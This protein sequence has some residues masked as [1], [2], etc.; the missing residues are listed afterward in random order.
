MSRHML[1][2]LKHPN[3]DRV[4][5]QEGSSS[6]EA[7]NST[8]T[9]Q[10]LPHGSATSLCSFLRLPTPI[11]D[12]AVSERGHELGDFHN[13]KG[14][15]LEE[16][17]FKRRRGLHD[18]GLEGQEGGNKSEP[19]GLKSEAVQISD[20]E[21][22]AGGEIFPVDTPSPRLFEQ[23]AAE[24]PKGPMTNSPW[25]KGFLSSPLKTFGSIKA[26]GTNTAPPTMSF[27]LPSPAM[28]L[29]KDKDKT[30]VTKGSKKE[31]ARRKDLP[32]SSSVNARGKPS[33]WRAVELAKTK[34]HVESAVKAIEKDYY[35]NSSR[36][37]IESRRN[38]INN[39]FEQLAWA[40]HL[41]PI[42]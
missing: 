22:T 9:N 12:V 7:N 32:V 38:T 36:N 14:E 23:E 20:E 29:G 41:T 33:I 34:A 21:H 40:F 17:S 24:V 42:L 37:A 13:Q 30:N 27:K 26:W 8:S 16:P 1:D 4:A 28:L 15:R 6:R 5:S 31:K 39:S 10:R 11:A 3:P 2:L 18:L 19:S 35:A 25:W